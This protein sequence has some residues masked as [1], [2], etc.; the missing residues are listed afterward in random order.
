M[1]IVIDCINPSDKKIRKSFEVEVESSDDIYNV[2]V[3]IQEREGIP[4]DQ[5]RLGYNGVA[6]EHGRTLADYNITAGT[7]L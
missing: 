5:Q 7:H 2:M 4:P 3:R 1:R 6:L